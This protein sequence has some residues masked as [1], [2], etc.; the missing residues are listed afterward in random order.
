[1]N[2]IKQKAINLLETA[3]GKS[4]TVLA[5]RAWEPATFFEVDVHFPEM[6]MSGWK[7]V[8]HIK[9]KVAPGVYRD[10]T[11]A[12]WDEDIR[13]CTLY[14]NAEQHGPGSHW[15]RSL[16]EGDSITYVGV[17]PTTHGPSTV[18]EMVVLGDMSSIGHYLALQQLAGP[19][20]LTGAITIEDE[21]HREEF[22]EYFSWNI[23]PVRKTDMG[24]LTSMLKW[25]KDKPLAHSNVYI[26][27]H[28]PT[29]VRL[30]KELKKRADSPR[31]IHVQGFW[32]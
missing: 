5:I 7:R 14:I 26:S 2:I 16:R 4:G 24:G 20:K 3:L 17:G 27:G 1:M 25:T 30:R 28:I 22:K 15:I 9:V 6:D 13:T 18:A 32:S 29:C 31:G 12:G 10:Y 11:P 19:R 23:Q 8:Q 21:N